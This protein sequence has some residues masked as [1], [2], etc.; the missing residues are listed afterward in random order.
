MEDSTTKQVKRIP[1][2]TGKG[3]FQ[4]RPQ[5]RSDGRWSKD[6]SFSYWLNYF[7]S[8]TTKEFFEWEKANPSD[9]RTVASDLAY[10][11]V[12]KARNELKEFQEV[13]NRTEGM[14]VK[15]MEVLGKIDTTLSQEEEEEINEFIRDIKQSRK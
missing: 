5:D 4:E 6:N 14:P 7:K 10:A 3:G 15:K 2:P 12:M 8:L 1:N 11:R 13:A 9:M